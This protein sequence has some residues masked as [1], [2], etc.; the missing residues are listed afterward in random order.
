MPTKSRQGRPQAPFKNEES[1]FSDEKRM[2]DE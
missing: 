2:S 1:D